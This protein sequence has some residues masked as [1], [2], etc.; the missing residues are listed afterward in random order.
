MP[1]RSVPR[2]INAPWGQFPMPLIKSMI[3]AFRIKPPTMKAPGTKPTQIARTK[4]ARGLT[5]YGQT[6]D[7]L[8]CGVCHD[9][10]GENSL[11]A[12]CE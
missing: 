7:F 11:L 6:E 12:M 4:V 10:V 5:N 2:G 1:Q 8:P 9:G 3:N